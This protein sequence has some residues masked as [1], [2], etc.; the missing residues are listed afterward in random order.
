MCIVPVRIKTSDISPLIEFLKPS[1]IAATFYVARYRVAS[2]DDVRLILSGE[3]ELVRVRGRLAESPEVREFQAGRREVAYS[4]AT[5]DV[6][7][8]RKD[9]HEWRSAKGRIATRLRGELS[10]EFFQGPFHHWQNCPTIHT[11]LIT[12]QFLPVRAG[13]HWYHP[14]YKQ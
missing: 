8:M 10:A 6:T 5:L 1:A 11:H 13:Y 9:K 12:A 14:Q 7:A 3:P 2:V 4:Y